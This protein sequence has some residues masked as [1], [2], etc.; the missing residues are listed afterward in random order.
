MFRPVEMTEYSTELVR[1]ASFRVFVYTS[2]SMLKVGP[3]LLYNIY[4]SGGGGTG[5]RDL[6]IAD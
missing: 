3:G 1:I 2:I 4:I 5:V 6:F